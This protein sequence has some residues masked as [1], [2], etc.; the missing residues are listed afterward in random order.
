M[1]AFILA[2]GKGTRLASLWPHPKIL[3]PI[4]KK[5]L[6]ARQVS[7][8]TNS[9]HISD[10]TFIISW[11]A[12]KII[13]YVR[14]EQL[15]CSWIRVPYSDTGSELA[16]G[17]R[18]LPSEEDFL[19]ING[20]TLINLDIHAFIINHQEKKHA[21]SVAVTHCEDISERGHTI[22]KAGMVAQF[23]EKK[24]IK[25]PGI[26][27]AGAYIL[28]RKILSRFSDPFSLERDVFPSLVHEKE[29]TAFSHQG[30]L[31]DCGTPDRVWEAELFFRERENT[32]KS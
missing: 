1:K 14:R 30:Y 5:P 10:I 29:L 23:Q 12:E 25:E 13:E 9:S 28:N 27:N 31:F 26:V 18:G 4:N 19:V 20:D 11:Q 32:R 15:A 21:S 3:F 24:T 2:A 17:V 16:H 7:F 8:F 22:V 6:L